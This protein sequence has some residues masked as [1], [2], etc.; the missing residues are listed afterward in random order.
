[1]K[2]PE[3]WKPGCVCSMVAL[4]PSDDCWVHGLGDGRFCPYCGKFRYNN[5][6]KSCGC[7]YGIDKMGGDKKMKA[8]EIIVEIWYKI[9]C[10]CGAVNWV[11]DGYFP[12]P[13]LSKMDVDGYKC[14]KCHKEFPFSD[15]DV[16]FNIEDGKSS[17]E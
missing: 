12:D 7:D 15:E 4:A 14:W 1:M 2:C 5:V 6:C 8:T 3:G 10:E 11:Y 9:N 16:P 13:D 17:P